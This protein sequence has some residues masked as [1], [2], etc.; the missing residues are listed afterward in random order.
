[1]RGIRFSIGDPKSR[2][3]QP[4]MIEP[5]ARRIAPLGWH[6]QFNMEGEQVVELA[7]ILRRLPTPLVFDHLGQSAAAG[8]HRPSVARD[9][10]RA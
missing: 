9:H 5:L 1:M 2:V 10:P 4:D 7:D 6:I 3:V 8:R